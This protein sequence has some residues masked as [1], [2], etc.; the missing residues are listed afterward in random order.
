MRGGGASTPA[1]VDDPSGDGQ[2]S[3]PPTHRTNMRNPGSSPTT[4]MCPWQGEVSSNR[5]TL[6]GRS[7]LVSP[8]VVEM[9]KVPCRT[10][11]N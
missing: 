4:V 8:S 6:P 1:A 10:M 9:E 3:P 5:N 7:R 11:P 2:R